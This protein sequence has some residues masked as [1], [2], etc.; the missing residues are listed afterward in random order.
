MSIQ[1]L[2]ATGINAT[3]EEEIV[4]LLGERGPL[5]VYQIAKELGTSY[6]AAQY[7]LERLIKRRKVYAVK[8]GARRYV[9]LIGQDWLKAVTVGDIV[10]ELSAALRRAKVKP[11]M[12]LREA[13]EVLERTSPHAAEALIHMAAAIH[14]ETQ[15]QTPDR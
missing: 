1:F 10:E 7:Y 5:P 12:P 13:L 4:R 2:N 9:A 8:V 6:G 3:V 15:Y 11:K 14:R